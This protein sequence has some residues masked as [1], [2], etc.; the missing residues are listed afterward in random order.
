MELINEWSNPHIFD[1]NYNCFTIGSEDD[2]HFEG[3]WNSE[4]Y[5]EFNTEL[6]EEDFPKK[7]VLTQEEIEANEK[8]VKEEEF[9]RLEQEAKNKRI[10]LEKE[11]K[12]LPKEVKKV[13]KVV[14]KEVKK[15]FRERREGEESVFDDLFNLKFLI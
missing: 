14:V 4:H 5:I 9:L 3:V 13:E 2:R 7:K 11:R 1:N 8:K 6:S 15:E 10:Q 12:S